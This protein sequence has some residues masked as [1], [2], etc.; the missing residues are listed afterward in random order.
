[1]TVAISRRNYVL[2][3]I[4]SLDAEV[5]NVI[6]TIKF[7]FTQSLYIQFYFKPTNYRSNKG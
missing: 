2:K 1:M 6:V 7:A 3:K 4:F 5:E